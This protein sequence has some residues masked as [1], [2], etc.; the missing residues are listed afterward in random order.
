[1]PIFLFTHEQIKLVI[2]LLQALSTLAGAF[3]IFAIGGGF[4]T[5]KKYDLLT[6]FWTHTSAILDQ[7]L[8][9][10]NSLKFNSSLSEEWIEFHKLR[11]EHQNKAAD[12]FNKLEL[13]L[14]PQLSFTTKE[15]F[16]LIQR[17]DFDYAV[18]DDHETQ[19]EIFYKNREKILKYRND[20]IQN[21][22]SE[23]SKLKYWFLK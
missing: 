15:I 8:V 12:C 7:M 16:R 2:E 11:A 3:A 23:F 17:I 6:D 9:L 10:T 21:L 4:L 1:M 5:R 22:K 13:F 18:K 14:D 19:K 20:L